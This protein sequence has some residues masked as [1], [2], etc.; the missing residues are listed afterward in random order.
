MRSLMAF[1][2]RRRC[3]APPAS[4]NATVVVELPSSDHPMIHSHIH[5]DTAPNCVGWWVVISS[6]SSG[7]ATGCHLKRPPCIEIVQDLSKSQEHS[8]KTH[9]LNQDKG[10]SA[11][12]CK[13]IA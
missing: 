13:L 8:M 3:F 11:Q 12:G 6:K 2:A 1:A 5:Q 4:L 7:L 10:T 9:K